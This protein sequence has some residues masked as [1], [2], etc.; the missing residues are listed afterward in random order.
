MLA[1]GLKKN[2][3]VIIPA[4]N[5]IA[6]F[7]VCKILNANV[8]LADVD[9]ITGQMTAETLKECIKVNKIKKVK[10]IISMYLGGNALNVKEFYKIKKRYDCFLIEDACH[11]LGSEYNDGNKKIRIGSCKHSD[12][13]TFSFHPIKSITTAEGGA[14]TTNNKKIIDK[15]ALLRSH[16]IIR[17]DKHKHWD[18]DVKTH[19][20]NFR[21]SD[22]NCALGISQLKKLKKFI[23]F[24]H[25]QNPKTPYYSKLK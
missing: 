2:D 23:S 11:A 24:R 12:V 25:P 7:N 6:S 15:I 19:G 22:L 18:Y 14:I 20:Y 21:L 3:N 13:C 1:I 8:Y 4:I 17:N 9:P 16:G 5:F 10:L